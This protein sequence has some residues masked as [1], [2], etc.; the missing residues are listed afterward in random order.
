MKRY[1]T[2]KTENS[3]GGYDKTDEY[4]EKNITFRLK[5]SKIILIIFIFLKLEHRFV[6]RFFYYTKNF[7]NMRYVF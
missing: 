5:T 7:V 1:I 4:D 3:S 6:L 2:D